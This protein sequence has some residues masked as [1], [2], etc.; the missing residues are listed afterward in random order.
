MKGKVG[1]GGVRAGALKRASFNLRKGVRTGIVVS[2]GSVDGV[3]EAR[4][5]G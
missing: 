3:L 4:Y 1:F 5:K 2:R